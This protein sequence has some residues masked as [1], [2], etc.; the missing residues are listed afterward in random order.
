MPDERNGGSHWPSPEDPWPDWWPVK[1]RVEYPGWWV[2]E[3]VGG[4][5]YARLMLSS[6]PRVVRGEDTEDLKGEI[7]REIALIESRVFRVHS[8]GAI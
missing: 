3:G 1:Y 2:W 5:R 6:P 7:I 4:I 8:P